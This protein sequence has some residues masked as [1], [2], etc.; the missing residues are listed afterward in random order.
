MGRDDL[1]TFGRS[2]V[3]SGVVFAVE[4]ALV[5]VLDA[6]GLAPAASFAAVQLV[7]TSVGFVLNKYWAFGAAHSGCGRFEGARSLVVFVGSFVLNVALPSLAMHAMRAPAV[8]AFTG[9]QVLVGLAWNFPLNRWWV[10]P[11]SSPRAA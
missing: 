9:S 3:V 11:P 2:V 7:G 4:L 5:A 8:V 10:F 1:M 6:S